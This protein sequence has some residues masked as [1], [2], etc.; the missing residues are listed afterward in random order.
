M[1]IPRINT[2]VAGKKK[3]RLAPA[4]RVGNAGPR[5]APQEGIGPGKERNFENGTSLVADT[6]PV[7]GAG[8]RTVRRRVEGEAIFQ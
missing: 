4:G 7:N 8:S 3:N 2:R 5:Y 1:A 6:E